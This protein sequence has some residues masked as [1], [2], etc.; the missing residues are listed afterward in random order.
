MAVAYGIFCVIALIIIGVCYIVNKEKDAYLFLLSVSVFVCNFGYFLGAVAK[1]LR[2]ALVA[3]GIAYLGNIFLPFFVLFMII[4]LCGISCKKWISRSLIVL[5]AVFFVL[6]ISTPYTG[7]YYKEVSIEMMNGATRLIRAYGP[8][9][10]VY[11]VYLLLYTV[12]MLGVVLHSVAKKKVISY[13]QVCFLLTAALGN[14]II[15]LLEQFIPREFEFLAVAYLITEVM[16]LLLYGIVHQYDGR[17]ELPDVAVSKK[18]EAERNGINTENIPT[19][20]SEQQIIYICKHCV[21]SFLLTEREAQVLRCILKNVRRKVIAEELSVTESTI[22]KHT[23]Q[24]FKKLSVN[25]RIE[26]FA[27]VSQL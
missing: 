24:I 25:N 4:R 27:K 21:T 9:H 17:Y 20:F 1:T 14:V 2:M 23:A 10:N 16:I 26:L 15:W 11:Y 22:K 3:N 5:A 6:I 18:A 7:L 13:L 19:L 8:L 12:S